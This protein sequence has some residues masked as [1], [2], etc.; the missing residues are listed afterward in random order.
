MIEYAAAPR[1]ESPRNCGDVLHPRPR[2]DDAH[3]VAHLE[4]QVVGGE[5]VDVATTNAGRHRAEPAT[6]VQAVERLSGHLGVR[7]RDTPVVDLRAVEGEGHGR[8]MAHL[9]DEPVHGLLVADDGDD[10]AR[11]RDRVVGGDVDVA[12]VAGG[13]AAHDP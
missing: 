5:Q 11:H 6:Q 10:V 4:N 7:H 2:G 9:G 13:V 1:S 12:G 3:A 8:G